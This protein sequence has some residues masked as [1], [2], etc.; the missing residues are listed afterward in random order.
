VVNAD[1][2]VAGGEETVRTIRKAGDEAIFCQAS[3]ASSAGCKRLVKAAIDTCRRL[4]I[5]VKNAGIE[6]RGGILSLSKEEW[7]AILDVDLK[8][9]FENL[10]NL[11]QIPVPCGFLVSALPI[12]LRGATATPIRSLTPFRSLGISRSRTLQLTV[13]CAIR[14]GLA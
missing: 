2:N 8:G 9:I 6:I 11:D 13:G 3:V 10:I 5:L 14:C 12:K 7:D 4:D 1:K